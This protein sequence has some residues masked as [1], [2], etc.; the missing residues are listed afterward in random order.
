M[1]A[2][3]EWW[4]GF[5][6]GPWLRYQLSKDDPGLVLPA[7]DFLE[8]VLDLSPGEKVLDAPCGDGRLGR[9]F[10]RR[11]YR[12]TGLD[13]TAAFLKA[14]RSKAREHGVDMDWVQG[15]MRRLR[16][17]N[18]Y[19]LLLCWWTSFGFF[20]DDGNRRQIRAAARALK[21]GGVL[22]L[23]LHSP[24]TLFPGFARRDWQERG[25]VTV[26]TDSSYDVDTG[27]TETDWTLIEKGRRHRAHSSIRLYTV[28]ELIELCREEGFDDFRHFGDLEGEPFGLEA[29]RLIFLATKSLG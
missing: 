21:P 16:W 18:R 3:R 9:E 17:R 24:E 2:S 25:G 20:D 22:A 23:D 28:R 6:R 11:G 7:V 26:I 15:D 8:A 13:S 12:V 29:S 10:A 27:R 1:A 5:F 19:H 14:G 4:E